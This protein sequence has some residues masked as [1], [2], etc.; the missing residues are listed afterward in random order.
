MTAPRCACGAGWR[1]HRG[2]PSPAILRARARAPARLPPA[3][4][5]RHR[6]P[7][8]RAVEGRRAPAHCSAEDAAM[9]VLRTRA[10]PP[11]TP[12][13]DAHQFAD[14]RAGPRPTL[15]AAQAWLRRLIT[16]LP[17]RSPWSATSSARRHPARRAL[18]RR[19]GPRAA[20]RPQ[21]ALEPRRSRVRP[22]VSASAESV[23]VLT[24]QAG[25]HERLLR[26]TSAMCGTRGPQHWPRRVCT[27]R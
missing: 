22:V 16:M 5:S 19:A 14:R 3:H 9:Q 18:S 6:G 21:D 15:P 20:H 24:P 2:L 17:S 4:R 10:R 12:G 7:A 27:T 25:R 8:S 23:V 1:G 13:G 11:S 26:A